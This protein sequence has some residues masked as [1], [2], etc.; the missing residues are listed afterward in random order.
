MPVRQSLVYTRFLTLCS[1][2]L[3]RWN[4]RHE[5]AV[6]KAHHVVIQADDVLL[7]RALGILPQDDTRRLQRGKLCAQKRR[8]LTVFSQCIVQFMRVV[9]G[10]EQ[11]VVPLI[12]R[13]SDVFPAVHFDHSP[14]RRAVGVIVNDAFAQRKACIGRIIIQR[15]PILKRKRLRERDAQDGRRDIDDPRRLRAAYARRDAGACD[16]KRDLCRIF[17]K[18]LFAEKRPLADL[19]AMIVATVLTVTYMKS[20]KEKTPVQAVVDPE[21]MTT[22]PPPIYGVSG[23]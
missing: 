8:R 17:E 3:F 18:C 23:L 2:V 11:Q 1:A 20:L 12:P 22:V 19:I 4:R 10:V 6:V 14:Q 21:L 13:V 15:P 5:A 16:E 7:Q 9:A